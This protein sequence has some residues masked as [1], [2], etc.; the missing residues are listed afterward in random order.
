MKILS[1]GK[2][3]SAPPK[4]CQSMKNVNLRTFGDQRE[5][6]SLKISIIK[7]TPSADDQGRKSFW[8]ASKERLD[9]Q[10]LELSAHET[11]RFATIYTLLPFIFWKRIKNAAN[12]LILALVYIIQ[13]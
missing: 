12:T 13:H 6:P 2:F 9:A 4:A 7:I 11:E 1:L 5:S 8:D 10:N 3:Y